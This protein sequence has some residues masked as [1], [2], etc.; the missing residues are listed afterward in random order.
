ME[1]K[2]IDRLQGV[3]SRRSCGRV[4]AEFLRKQWV[5][6]VVPDDSRQVFAAR[7]LP[8]SILSSNRSS[9]VCRRLRHSS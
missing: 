1:A 3:S 9:T 7:S 6:R 8:R 2:W 4:A 5:Y